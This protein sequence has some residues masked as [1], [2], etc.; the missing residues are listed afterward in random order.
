MDDRKGGAT[1]IYKLRDDGVKYMRLAT[2]TPYGTVDAKYVPMSEIDAYI[3][4]YGIDPKVIDRTLVGGA[5]PDVTAVPDLATC[6]EL[7]AFGFDDIRVASMWCDLYGMDGNRHPLCVRGGLKTAMENNL[8][9]GENFITGSE[10]EYYVRE[11]D[12]TIDKNAIGEQVADPKYRLLL[13]TMDVLRANGVPITKAHPENGPAQ[14]E[15]VIK[16]G[17]ALTTADNYVTTGIIMDAKAAEGGRRVDRSPFMGDD[18]SVNSE[19]LNMSVLSGDKNLFAN[20][21]GVGVSDFGR[22]FAEGI[23]DN[24]GLISAVANTSENSY[25]A[26]AKIAK[27]LA[28]GDSRKDLIRLKNG[29]IEY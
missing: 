11:A 9:D 26:L 1:T 7:P 29:L 6:A 22:A 12:G 25:R 5:L 8:G 19:H 4:G 16:H 21:N 24:N 15:Q 28:A 3:S 14:Y 17:N 10:R 23:L 13:S 18:I 2:V 27:T 20:A